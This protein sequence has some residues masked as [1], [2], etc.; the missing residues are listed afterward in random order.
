[1]RIYVQKVGDFWIPDEDMRYDWHRLWKAGKRRR[2]SRQRYA[3]GKGPKY[4]DIQ[5]ALTHIPGT[6]VA[7]DGGA[8][9]GA[10]SRAM[11]QHFKKV[12]A[13]EPAPDTFAALSRNLEDWGLTDRVSAYHAAISDRHENVSVDLPRG[14]RSVSRRIT[15]PGDIPTMMI[16]DLKLELVDFIKLDL[17]GYEYRALLGAAGT[18]ERCRPIVMFEDKGKGEDAELKRA[19]DY[20][21]SLGARLITKIGRQQFDW[22]YGFP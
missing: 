8:N 18:L 20:L 21:L 1:M 10:Y 17:E 16:D 14:S 5:E 12:H 4:D 6:E 9:V 15:G 22:L 11:A 3:D 7:V 13:F 2:K 19:H